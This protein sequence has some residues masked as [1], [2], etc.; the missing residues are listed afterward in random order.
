VGLLSEFSTADT[1][2]AG[3]LI[4]LAIVSFT[5]EHVWFRDANEDRRGTTTAIFW[6]SFGTAVYLLTVMG[7]NL[8]PYFHQAVR[9]VAACLLLSISYFIGVDRGRGVKHRLKGSEITTTSFG[10]DIFTAF[11][12]CSGF[13]GYCADHLGTTVEDADPRYG[14]GEVVQVY[15][16]SLQERDESAATAF[17]FTFVPFLCG[18]G[19]GHRKR[20]ALAREVLERENQAASRVISEETNGDQASA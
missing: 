1:A 6:S 7:V 18:L 17:V 4:T 11:I 3:F 9:L 2:F 14:G 12:V 20:L 16:P 13:A 10:L 19:A 8:E 5:S 15:E